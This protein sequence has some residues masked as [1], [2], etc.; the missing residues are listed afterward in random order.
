[1]ARTLTAETLREEI[2]KVEAQAAE[3]F[4]AAEALKAEMAESEVNPLTDSEA[5]DKVDAAYREYSELADQTAQMRER[6]AAMSGWGAGAGP[7]PRPYDGADDEG[8]PGL[9]TAGRRFVE[10]PEYQALGGQGALETDAAF[11]SIAG[12]GLARPVTVIDRNAIEAALMQGRG[13]RAATVTGGGAT[14]GG[15]ST[16]CLE[17]TATSGWAGRPAQAGSRPSTGSL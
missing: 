15:P 13:F 14:S 1:M 5:F 16:G 2:E 17:D 6:L 4:A 9:M 3:K 8:A 7:S 11:A 10:S 12:Q